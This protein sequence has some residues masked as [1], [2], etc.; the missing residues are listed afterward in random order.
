MSTALRRFV[1]AYRAVA[2]NAVRER[3]GGEARDSSSRRGPATHQSPRDTLSSLRVPRLA[4]R[5]RRSAR[6]YFSWPG[7][8]RS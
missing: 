2:G 7:G 8:G 6:L 5:M 1:V 4:L 3:P